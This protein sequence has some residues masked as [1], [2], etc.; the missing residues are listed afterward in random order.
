M[1]KFT[2]KWD[3][4][5]NLE[6]KDSLLP[7]KIS[8]IYPAEIYDGNFCEEIL[9]EE[10]EKYYYAKKKYSSMY[11]YF[12]KEFDDYEEIEL[13]SKE[14][15]YKKYVKT[16]DE[17]AKKYRDE[18]IQK[19]SEYSSIDFENYKIEDLETFNIED[20]DF[21]LL[22][23]G[24]VN[25]ITRDIYRKSMPQYSLILATE[26]T[27]KL[28]DV[29]FDININK[30]LTS[31]DDYYS[32]EYLYRDNISLIDDL[33]I[34][35]CHEYRVLNFTYN[36]NQVIM[37]SLDDFY[38]IKKLIFEDVSFIDDFYKYFNVE[39]NKISII[40]HYVQRYDD[41]YNIK[42]KCIFRTSI[43]KD[44]LLEE[45]KFEICYK[46]LKVETIY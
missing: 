43:D 29:V 31:Y 11:D 34:S 6:W 4:Y 5:I 25:L 28:Y 21:K 24:R 20:V 45:H 10:F 35:Y 12:E 23:L 42:F 9:N 32:N 17:Q 22:A 44:L 39:G 38:G 19:I 37:Y 41:C 36:D 46:N 1:K 27:D 18:F 33:C 13:L 30:F 3:D 2:K 14:D 16:V 26:N 40:D 8:V 7:K 15:E